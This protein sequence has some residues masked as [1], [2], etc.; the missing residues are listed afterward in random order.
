MKRNLPASPGEYTPP[1]PSSHAQ[2]SDWAA[3]RRGEDEDPFALGVEFDWKRYLAAL[4]RFKWLVLVVVVAGTSA[5]VAATRFVHPQYQAQATIWIEGSGAEPGGGPIRPS[6]LLQSQAW[7]DLLRSYVVLDSVVRELRLYL[8]QSSPADSALFAGFN[9]KQRFIPGEYLLTIDAPGTHF[10]LADSDGVLIQRGQVGDSIGGELGFAW[11]PSPQALE[12]GTTYEFA[13]DNP[14]DAATQLGEDLRTEMDKNGNFLRLRLRGQDAEHVATVLNAVAERYV[15]VAADLKSAKLRE[16]TGILDD[17]V[18]YARERLEQAEA[19]L[20]NFRVATITLPSDRSTPIAPG[21]E[22]TRDPV[23]SGFFELRVERENL[24]RDREAIERVLRQAAD[25]GLA[26]EALEIIPAVRSSSE[27]MTALTEL[28]NKR[29]EL[30]SLLHRYTSEHPPVRDLR[31]EV[32]TLENHTIP[33]MARSVAAELKA[34]EDDLTELIDSA[35][36]ELTEI[37]PRSIEEA[38]LERRVEGAA[39]LYTNLQ[40]R[41]EE[42]RLAAASAIPDVRVLDPAIAPRRPVNTRQS[43]RIIALAFMVS[44]ALAFFGA[45]FLDRI[46]PM[47]RYPDQ[48]SEDLGLPI[49]ASVPHVKSRDGSLAG[50]SRSQVVEAF[51]GLRLSLLSAYGAAGP[52]LVTVTSS[53]PEEGKSFVAANLALAFS[54]LGK[55]TVIVDGDIRRGRLHQ[56]LGA[57]RKPGLTDYLSRRAHE[58]QVVKHASLGA[59]DIVPSGTRRAIGPELLHSARMS[60]F[61]ADLKSQYEVVLVDSPPMAAGVDPLVL[62]NMTGSMLLVLRTGATHREQ[63]DAQLDAVSRLPIRVLGAV[64]NDVPVK[65]AYGYYYSAYGAY[66]ALPGYESEDE[67]EEESWT[68]TRPDSGV[69]PE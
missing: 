67:E 19:E 24:S 6:R 14:R 35:S 46:D 31:D 12:P 51:R 66:T 2:A 9:L 53:G 3:S 26:V 18:D 59:I 38:R 20:E 49:L 10:G 34:Q 28:T 68:V 57:D 62:A 21:L 16:L 17:Q 8:N 23:F 11:R 39:T 52:V 43:E 65:G 1:A 55:R 44:F 15:E 29:A 22:I 50:S 69:L 54:D 48:V 25:S 40:T 42:A 41:Y 33:R 61:F 4:W 45:I 7:V 63:M 56:V 13:V 47:L 36:G 27:L 64:L 5:G 32:A 60:E 30:R 37:P 58:G